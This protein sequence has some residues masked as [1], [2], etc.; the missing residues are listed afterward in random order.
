MVVHYKPLTLSAATGVVVTHI[1]VKRC[2][3]GSESS[4]SQGW[5]RVFK[6]N[7]RRELRAR[8]REVSNRGARIGVLSTRDVEGAV[9]NEKLLELILELNA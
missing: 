1:A 2:A 6:W 3:D 5:A 8:W 4:L 9:S 7:R